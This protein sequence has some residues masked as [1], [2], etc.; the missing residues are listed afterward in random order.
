MFKHQAMK[1]CSL[2]FA[3][4]EPYIHHRKINPPPPSNPANRVR[5]IVRFADY[6][7]TVINRQLIMTKLENNAISSNKTLST[8]K[9]SR[10]FYVKK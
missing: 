1:A 6:P 4:A 7:W 3:Y 9:K 5:S 10:I 2:V 8:N